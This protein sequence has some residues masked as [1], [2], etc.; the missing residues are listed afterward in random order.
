MKTKTRIT[1]W[2]VKYLNNRDKE[3]FKELNDNKIGTSAIRGKIKKAR[4]RI[5][6]WKNPWN[7]TD[8]NGTRKK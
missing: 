6:D 5:W 1:T 4:W 8:G 7:R 2:D 3:E